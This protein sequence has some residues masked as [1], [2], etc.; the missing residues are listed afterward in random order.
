MVFTMLTKLHNHQI[1]SL[2]HFHQPKRN[3]VHIGSQSRITFQ[4]IL[5]AL[6][7]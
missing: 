4:S 6:G 3:P 7:V 1:I 5:Q 2:E